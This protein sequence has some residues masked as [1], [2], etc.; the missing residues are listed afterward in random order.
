MLQS[1]LN[2]REFKLAQYQFSRNYVIEDTDMGL[3]VWRFSSPIFSYATAKL[4]GFVDRAATQGSKLVVCRSLIGKRVET[5][6][7]VETELALL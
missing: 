3:C 5:S 7:D 2:G 6:F 4:E 1:I